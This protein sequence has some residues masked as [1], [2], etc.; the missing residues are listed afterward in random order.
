MAM[1]YIDEKYAELVSQGLNLGQP[2]GPE[3]DAGYGGHLRRYEFGNIY[4]HPDVDQGRAH[5]VHGEI[6][7]KYRSC[8]EVGDNPATGTRNLGFPVTD[9]QL[10]VDGI[11]Q[12]GHFQWGS[13]YSDAILGT[14]AIW[15]RLWDQWK[16]NGKLGYPLADPALVE[17]GEVIFFEY[18]SIYT[19]D[20][21]NGWPIHMNAFLPPL[22]RPLIVNP[23][24]PN[25]HL[26]L[27]VIDMGSAFPPGARE[28][29]ELAEFPRR[30]WK[31]RIF[32]Q[33]VEARG[34]SVR[35]S[36]IHLGSSEREI[37][38]SWRIS[39]VPDFHR[40][41]IDPTNTTYGSTSGLLRMGF[42]VAPNQLR[43]RTLYDVVVRVPDGSLRVMAP[44]AFY[45]KKSWDR[46]GFLHLTDL[47]ISRRN[48]G[49]YAKLVELGCP[50]G[51]REYSNAQD[52][53]RELIRYANFLHDSG[54]LDFIVATGDLVDYICEDGEQPGM[55][56]NFRLLQE[57]LLG[58]TCSPNAA[59]SDLGE[60]LRVPFFPA[61]GN[62]DY[63]VWP[64]YLHF[65]VDVPI[66]DDRTFDFYREHNL[67][68]AET[69]ALQGRQGR[70]TVSSDDAR[71][72]LEIDI[73]NQRRAYDYYL[74]RFLYAS[75]WPGGRISFGKHKLV[76]LDTGPDIGTI[77]NDIDA[78]AAYLVGGSA[79]EDHFLQG[80]PWSRGP[81]LDDIDAVRRALQDMGADGL[82]IVAMHAPP[83]DL[84]E[85]NEFFRESQ[86]ASVDPAHVSDFLRRHSEEGD[87]SGWT[88]TGRPYFKVGGTNLLDRGFGRP[89]DFLSTCLGT[90]RPVDLVLCGH[91]GGR[92]EY[93]FE[94]NPDGPG[95]RFYTDFF[96]ENPNTYYCSRRADA[97]RVHV[98]VR[99]G[100]P[101]SG[102]LT[103]VRDHRPGVIWTEWTSVEVPPYPETLNSAT[104]LE[105]WWQK[106]RPLVLQ[107]APLGMTE[108]NQ[109]EDLTTNATKPGPSFQGFRLVSVEEGTIRRIDYVCIADVKGTSPSTFALPWDKDTQ[110]ATYVPD[111]FLRISSFSPTSGPA[112]TNVAIEGTRFTQ[113]TRVFFGELECEV[114]S[115]N[116][117]TCIHALIPIY[118][119]GSDL[120]FVQEGDTRVAGPGK[121]EVK[122][123]GGLWP[124]GVLHEHLHE[125]PHPVADHHHHP[126]YHPHAPGVNHHHAYQPD[127]ASSAESWPDRIPHEH[128]HDHPHEPCDHHHHAHAHPHRE[129]ANHHHPC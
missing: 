19:G 122:V 123:W 29:M 58:K 69:E 83:I 32:V 80:E 76:L 128:A 25:P 41:P 88:L 30:L 10:S 92:A 56:G 12:V 17:G 50:D 22:G 9:Q 28:A 55:A 119:Q 6:L 39:P 107:T 43:D 48:E 103:H 89:D 36:T 54:F 109:R 121:F 82:V 120:L 24:D 124:D 85:Y 8:G 126:H 67:T 2:V 18:G 26:T 108:S 38:G 129:V 68:T 86:H 20:W 46:F 71:K 34:P 57:I 102:R 97:G 33:S 90:S 63:R 84:F 3:Q 114:V 40:V 95:F 4:W 66:F 72:G 99:D 105:E 16:L 91:L 14:V 23:D 47:H 94:R 125:H 100:A 64:Y 93:R 77:S 81:D 98:D 11:K 62:H 73:N 60:E 117:S 78:I 116:Q 127:E 5:E 1:T 42:V 49:F 31:D 45:A 61:R 51:A 110:G 104:N 115:R 15:G 113:N 74:N 70:V 112:G 44:H 59:L 79:A 65:K 21:T 111:L 52:N 53:L 27:G 101:P 118:A 13:I 35:D 106:H 96:T 37:P 7:T 75:P 87:G